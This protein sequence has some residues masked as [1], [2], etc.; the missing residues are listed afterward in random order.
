MKAQDQDTICLLLH[1]VQQ[2]NPPANPVC[3]RSPHLSA[4]LQFHFF[5]FILPMFDQ[6]NPIEITGKIFKAKSGM[7]PPNIQR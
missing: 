4:Q 6:A 3:E 2:E 5:I 1:L 7:L